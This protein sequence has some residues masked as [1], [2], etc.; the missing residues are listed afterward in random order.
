LT[1][2]IQWY[3]PI[4]GVGVIIGVWFLVEYIQLAQKHA[5]LFHR[6]LTVTTGRAVLF[7]S[8]DDDLHIWKVEEP[9][10]A[11]YYLQANHE[12][13]NAYA[14][15]AA[16]N[17]NGNGITMVNWVENPSWDQIENAITLDRDYHKGVIVG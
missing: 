12:S 7:D 11:P 9:G 14:I 13:A 10:K 8:S 1:L 5:K 3:H 6:D 15:K 17:G 4:I 2:D 16:F